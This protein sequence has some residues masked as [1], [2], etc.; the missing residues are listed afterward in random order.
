MITRIISIILAVMFLASIV[1]LSVYGIVQLKRGSDDQSQAVEPTFL[2]DFEPLTEP[3]A[4]LQTE[5]LVLG[6]TDLGGQPVP[7]VQATDTITVNYQGALASDGSIFA[8]QS[9]YTVGLLS[10]IA[11]WQEGLIGMTQGGKRR[12]LIPASLAYEVEGEDGAP[13][14]TDL[15]YDVELL[16]IADRRPPVTLQVCQ[17]STDSVA[18]EDLPSQTVSELCYEDLEVG[19]EQ[20]VESGQRVKVNYTGVLGQ[21]PSVVFDSGQEVSFGLDQ[22]IVG[23][24]EG[25]VG[26]GVGGKRRLF[27]P[28]N[29]A[30]GES[31]S[32]SIPANSDLIF[33]VEL[34][35]I[36]G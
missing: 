25:L 17:N 34:I 7:A 21:D 23:W 26:M 2:E 33:D 10:Q 36:E 9:E 27:I 24:Q 4:D 6:I 1:L 19:A 28:A 29:L 16:S 8:D 20:K 35:E 18:I 11:G 32:G 22:V 12:L 30:Y 13:A 15:V 14:Q 3:L 5:D 31:G